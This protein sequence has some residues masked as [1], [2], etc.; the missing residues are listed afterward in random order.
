VGDTRAYRLAGDELEQLTTD[1]TL[2]EMLVRN[3]LLSKADAREHPERHMLVQ[4]L[5]TVEIIEPE[6]I[7]TDLPEGAR[8]ILC[9]DGLHDLVPEAVLIQLASLESL[10]Q[11]A[12]A[13]VAAANEAGGTDNISVILVER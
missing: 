13:L 3:G 4:A 10:D 7:H 1:H 8:L 12:A 6:R 11:A 9:S 2:V 5:G